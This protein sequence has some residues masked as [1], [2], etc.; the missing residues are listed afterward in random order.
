M[1]PIEHFGV[2]SC[3]VNGGRVQCGLGGHQR[4][5][6][7]GGTGPVLQVLH[8]I[9]ELVSFDHVGDNICCWTIG[10]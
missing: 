5:R 7:D 2:D 9:L 6:Q 8:G 4:G 3:H 1:M 10:R